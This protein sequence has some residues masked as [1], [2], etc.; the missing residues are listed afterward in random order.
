M[1]LFIIHLLLTTNVNK[2][3]KI[4][5]TIDDTYA[6]VC[7]PYKVKRMNVKIFNLV[8]RVNETRFLIQHESCES[9]CRLNE[10]ACNSKPTQSYDKCRCQCHKLNN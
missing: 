9:K 6:R 2:C 5:N 8:P 4:C 3:C 7:F 1:D 10:I